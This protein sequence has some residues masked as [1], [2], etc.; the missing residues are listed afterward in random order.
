MH[1]RVLLINSLK[2]TFMVLARNVT[3]AQVSQ[4][5]VAEQ[6]NQLMSGYKNARE[7]HQHI[8]SHVVQSCCGHRQVGH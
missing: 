5:P 1:N 8:A 7:H 3:M 2:L 4:G 6:L